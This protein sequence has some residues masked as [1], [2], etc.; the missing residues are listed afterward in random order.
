MTSERTTP[1]LALVVD[2]HPV[3][4][5]A[6]AAALGA[7]GIG[8]VPV[9]SAAAAVDRLTTTRHD[10]VLLDVL[11][12]GTDGIALAHTIAR[13]WPGTPVCMLSAAGGAELMSAA[14]AAGAAGYLLKTD[15]PE[16]LVA[17]VRRVAAGQAVFSPDTLR[18][19]LGALRR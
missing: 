3:V 1:L 12:P 15:P 8:A 11:L 18:A 17:A 5:D 14:I 7:A 19:L 10:V 2:D 16:T 6:V 9:Y 4:A 13:R